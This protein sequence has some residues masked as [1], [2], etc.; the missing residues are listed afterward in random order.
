MGGF[1][2]RV[3]S[4]LGGADERGNLPHQVR[5]ARTQRCPNPLYREKE[6]NNIPRAGLSLLCTSARLSFGS[7]DI[8]ASPKSQSK[9]KNQPK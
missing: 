9:L 4:T 1:F 6:Y 2:I 7:G 5:T 8:L 3:S